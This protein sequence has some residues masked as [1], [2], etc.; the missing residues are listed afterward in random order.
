MLPYFLS[1]ILL[2][3]LASSCITYSDAQTAVQLE[4][5]AIETGERIIKY[6]DDFNGGERIV[7]TVSYD[8]KNK[9]PRWVAYDL[10][11]A[12]L[13]GTVS[14]KG[15]SFRPDEDAGVPQA[16]SYDYRNSGW[17]KGHLAPAGDFKWSNKAM[18]DT[19]FYTNCCP[20]TEYFNGTSWER[21]ESRVRSWARKFGTVYVVTGPIIGQAYNGVLGQNRITIPD[22]FFKGVLVRDGDCYQAIGFIMEN[23]S[24]IQ[25]YTSCCVTIDE[26]ERITGIDLFCN[27][28]DSVEGTVES[29]Y[30]THFWG[31]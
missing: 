5:P 29:S 17:T 21:L 23:T 14:R 2:A 27:L 16:D 20:Q 25:P 24:S 22:A 8:F 10:T 13:E 31:I 19:F 3:L 18:E 4:L 1:V 26:I 7:Y 15:L 12:E 30:D 6:V 9:Q 28:D 11:S